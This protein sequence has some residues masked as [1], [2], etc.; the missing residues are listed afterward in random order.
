MSSTTLGIDISKATFDAALLFENNKVKTKRFA[1]KQS[2]FLE[3]SA[4]LNRHETSKSQVCLEATGYYGEALATYLFEVG[5][6]VS[7]VN[8]AQIKGF[9]QCELIRTK[10]DKADAQLIARFC[11][12]MHP[13]AWKP[14]PLHIRELQALIHRL[15]SL[16]DMYRQEAN[17]LEA[18]PMSIQS[19]IK[20]IEKRLEKEI[21]WVKKKIQ[22]HIE[23]Y[24]DLRGKKELLETIPGVGE[25]TI[26]QV[27]AFIG[28]VGDFKHAKQVAAF[29]GLNPKHR[30][31]GTSVQGRSRL[32]KMGNAALRTAF[33]MPAIT[34]KRYNPVI[35]AF[36]ERLKAAGK[37]TMLIIG[38]AMRKLIHIIYGVLKSGKAFDA[39]VAT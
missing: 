33:Y 25:A 15:A 29:V 5:Y 35:K 1:N 26:A 23:Q 10:T 27:L 38:A 31:S 17:R 16:Q 4:W 30:Q 8:P 9:G 7:V 13:H 6:T 20:A 19:S 39:R 18:A 37:P 11:R 36:C 2:G 32:S 14:K 24:P 12:A 21:A 34:A 3:L 28:N 22:S